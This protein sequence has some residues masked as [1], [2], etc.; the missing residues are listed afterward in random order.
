MCLVTCRRPNIVPCCLQSLAATGDTVDYY[1]CAKV[2]QTSKPKRNIDWCR[3]VFLVSTK[4][5]SI[6]QHILFSSSIWPDAR[7]T[8]FLLLALVSG[9]G[10][11]FAAASS[12]STVLFV[13]LAALLVALVLKAPD[14][15]ALAV[16][17][18][19]VTFAVKS[20]VFST[21]TIEGLFY[22]YYF[23][24]IAAA[25]ASLLRGG[26]RVAPV[27]FWTIFIFF[28]FVFISLIGFT[29]P[30][31]SGFVQKFVTMLVCPLVLFSIQSSQGLKTVSVLGG[32]VGIAISV[33]VI[34]EA[35]RGGFAYRG[36][37]DVNQNIAAYVL[38]LSLTVVISRLMRPLR[39]GGG[40]QMFVLL[41]ASGTMAYASLLLASRGMTIALA[42]ST[43]AMIIHMAVRDLRAVRIA[44]LLAWVAALGLLLPGGDGLLQRFETE[45]IESAGDRTPIWTATIDALVEGSMIDFAI[46]HG[47]D[48]SKKVVR[49]ATAVHSST[50][51]AY[52]ALIFEYGI[53]GL[54]SFLA[55]HFVVLRRA[56]KVRTPFATLATGIIWLLLAA[57]L[58][59]TTHDDFTYWLALGFA[60]ACVS[61]GGA[62]NVASP[63]NEPA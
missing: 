36:D 24:F 1:G 2:A 56:A 11:G 62:N 50:H 26:L 40:I 7:A 5:R 38:G 51:N 12:P 35:A 6:L 23:A 20:V 31:D 30:V 27:V 44:L 46:G 52:L 42:V 37:V 4:R 3:K 59:A 15:G 61:V 39:K 17:A 33:W 53:L 48:S 47:F 13:G 22:P 34:W 63:R 49:D 57:N 29:H 14:A 19:W 41:V 10:V 55:M 21:V 25:L 43:A 16:G 45:S 60:M 8:W 18:Y 58:T 32:L 9:A 28:V 54:I